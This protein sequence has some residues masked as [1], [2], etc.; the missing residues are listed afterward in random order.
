MT[1]RAISAIP[2]LEAR[3]GR[4]EGNNEVTEWG[5]HSVE[6]VYATSGKPPPEGKHRASGSSEAAAG[7][8]G[9]GVGSGGGEGE[10]EAMAEAM[11]EPGTYCSPR[12]ESMLNPRL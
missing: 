8:G 1:W 2:Y 7:G 11:V 5:P 6:S 12:P 9:G 4:V 10:S 3:V